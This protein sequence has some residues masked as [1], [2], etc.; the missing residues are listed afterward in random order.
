[1]DG[2]KKFVPVVSP[3]PL[4]VGHWHMV[5]R[6]VRGVGVRSHGVPLI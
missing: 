1:M 6:L 3:K 4:G 2:G 5:G